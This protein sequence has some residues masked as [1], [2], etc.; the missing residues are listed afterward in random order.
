MYKIITTIIKIRQMVLLL[1]VLFFYNNSG[2]E[3]FADEF[4]KSVRR[5]AL[6]SVIN[7]ITL[8]RVLGD[9]VDRFN[10][11]SKKLLIL[12]QDA[13]CNYFAQNK[14]SRIIDYLNKEYGV[15]TINLEGGKGYYDLSVF[16]NIEDIPIR[17][18]VSDFFLKE[19]LVNGAEKFAANNPGRVF[20]WGIEDEDLYYENL[21]AYRKIL[22]E[23][24]RIRS[25]IKFLEDSVNTIKKAIYSEEL[26][27]ID[28]SCVLYTEK[29]K[30][31]QEHLNYLLRKAVEFKID[32][33]GLKNISI[34]SDIFSKEEDIDFKQTEI[35]RDKLIKDLS[36]ILSSAEI[37]ELFR[38]TKEF[39]KG[40]I[41]DVDFYSYITM[42]AM[43]I[44]LNIDGYGEFKKYKKYIELYDSADKGV[45]VK[46]LSILIGM[47]KK[48]LFRSSRE[49]ELDS[50]SYSV[51]IEK[52]LFNISLS[53]EEY[54]YYKNN[55]DKFLNKRFIDYFEKI[56][57]RIEIPSGFNEL[58]NYRERMEKFYEVSYRRDAA[59]MENIIFYSGMGY[60]KKT[61]EDISILLAGGFHTENITRLLKEHN[62]SFVVIRPNFLTEISYE[63]PYLQ[64]LSGN[65]GSFLNFVSEN[66]ST[67]AIGSSL[68]EMKSPVVRSK[69]IFEDAVRVKAS[70]ESGKDLAL[71]G[72]SGFV[73]FSSKGVISLE[74]KSL[75]E[76]KTLV[77]MM[78]GGLEKE[79][80]MKRISIWLSKQFI[81]EKYIKKEIDKA[82]N[83]IWSSKEIE[84]K[85]VG[86]DISEI[87]KIEEEILKL[88]EKAA[89][90]LVSMVKK[91]ENRTRDNYKFIFSVLA[92]I[93]AEYGENK[94]ASFM[95]LSLL[96]EQLRDRNKPYREFLL[97]SFSKA[98]K[99]WGLSPAI[100]SAIKKRFL[101]QLLACLKD[102]LNEDKEFI[103]K[104]L[105]K[106]IN[107][108][109]YKSV[110][111]YI[112]PIVLDNITD[113]KKSEN[114]SILGTI[115]DYLGPN[116]LVKNKI[117]P[118]VLLS[119]PRD[120]Y[121]YQMILEI[122][123]LCS[124]IYKED[125]KVILRIIERLV[126]FISD[127]N[128]SKEYVILAYDKFR[129]IIQLLPDNFSN[130]NFW[131]LI[132]NRDDEIMSGTISIKDILFIFRDAYFIEK[133]SGMHLSNQYSLSVA[134]E[135]T[136]KR[137]GVLVTSKNIEKILPFFM[138]RANQI[139]NR[140]I[141]NKDTKVLFISHSGEE[142]TP[143]I[144]MIFLKMFLR[145]PYQIKFVRGVNLK[146]SSTL[147][148][149]NKQRK[150]IIFDSIKKTNGDFTIWVTAHGGTKH[151]W[152]SIGELG[153]QESID[154][155]HPD[156][157][158][159]VEFGD[160]L[161]S[162]VDKESR[163]L[164]LSK[165]KIVLDACYSADFAINL[166]N[167]MYETSKKRNISLK[168]LPLIISAVQRGSK[169]WGE[170]FFVK[171]LSD[172]RIYFDG[173]T[174]KVSDFF[175]A[176]HLLTI[177][178]RNEEYNQFVS[179]D[180]AFFLPIADEEFEKIKNI[181]GEGKSEKE[182]PPQEINIDLSNHI[183]MKG[184]IQ[185]LDTEEFPN[186]D[187]DV[188]VIGL[189][190][191]FTNE[192]DT[193][194]VLTQNGLLSG[195]I[196]VL[197]TGAIINLEKIKQE[198]SEGTSIEIYITNFEKFFDGINMTPQER[199]IISEILSLFRANPPPNI[200]ILDSSNGFLGLG[201]SKA[202]AIDR[203]ILE[204][205][206]LGFLHEIIEY[207]KDVNPNIIKKMEL[208][209]IEGVDSDRFAG[210]DWLKQHEEKYLKQGFNKFFNDNKEHYIIRAFTRQVFREQD[211][212][213]T[214]LIKSRE[215][216]G[217]MIDA[218]PL[219]LEISRKAPTY[220][221][222]PSKSI[223]DAAISTGILSACQ[224]KAGKEGQLFYARNYTADENW[225]KNIQRMIDKLLPDFF[226]DVT[227][228]GGKSVYENLTR[229]IIRIPSSRDIKQND[230]NK[231]KILE[232]IK[233]SIEKYLEENG[234]HGAFRHDM[235]I[236][237]LEK[238]KFVYVDMEHAE[239]LNT[240]LDF[241]TDVSMV[242]C[243]RYE[244]D[245][246]GRFKS[247]SYNEDLPDSLK[248]NFLS[249]L[250]LSS[251]NYSD[252][253]ARAGTRDARKII[254]L[255]FEGYILRVKAIDWG[256]LQEFKSAE[257]AVLRSL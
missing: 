91:K 188:P 129:K 153:S 212:K 234:V 222:E 74:K 157:I 175:S 238:I 204:K 55:K 203:E 102:P 169:G 66:I 228:F 31:F 8:P 219:F 103:F 48:H 181:L 29:K 193:A 231:N 134:I 145:S 239:Y 69:A 42:K 253:I 144:D 111:K 47:I 174:L 250:R 115:A 207:V 15:D 170:S 184:Q 132:V 35:E 18:R 122:L 218:V 125:N 92:R 235:V 198:K 37:D 36:E 251:D 58:D 17:N 179:Q 146:T 57:G 110:E 95:I 38:K 100:N 118:K 163:V 72:N 96:D 124:D 19:G 164:D 101:P 63:S 147:E 245:S 123:Y 97:Y 141:L 186:L 23:I 83:K 107:I 77:E 79:P 113:F 105:D 247:D 256:S 133:T 121:S 62:I 120:L 162:R 28:N 185:T 9:I 229:M 84:T 197:E 54:F 108:L 200:I 159:Y 16:T 254:N 7:E 75:S 98:G 173:D 243:S 140:D 1:T 116:D 182:G 65:A 59:F 180:P 156:A 249:F 187:M 86:I 20:L 233:N 53:S 130:K 191:K 143:D 30:S 210:L 221:I 151:L 183:I 4:I 32:I 225:I 131:E 106:I 220:V 10:A 73:L 138:D 236:H 51:E 155:K 87:K 206:P 217:A 46:E 5:D 68:S 214:R 178:K 152:L 81:S 33:L 142:M 76:E 25:Y 148:G 26:L 246:E 6:P 67:L 82:F 45:L 230:S 44:K 109:D 171:A 21:G 232:Y 257:D 64:L 136:L 11:D 43:S 56:F 88:G 114:L 242:E 248:E 135:H 89:Y 80:L 189:I 70:I 71:L 24:E 255:I 195:R 241:F 85:G 215:I 139:M 127:N 150:N 167:Y 49:R 3:I 196:K 94:R 126:D 40:D 60:Q 237:V 137:F 13:H 244:K 177:G 208:T 211:E 172:A 176:E 61:R 14:V 149:F 209:L 240:L 166:F 154:L 168:E 205:E 90:Y 104:I 12:I 190:G 223:K 158:S 39:K 202:L 160:A 194:L 216:Y 227:S 226:N 50:I 99:M 34:F 161:M 2:V 112:L 119:Q 22:S 199:E 224:K 117:L 27:N 52:K 165:V 213:F 252:I 192:L 201:N 128:I 78:P 41:L 93:Y